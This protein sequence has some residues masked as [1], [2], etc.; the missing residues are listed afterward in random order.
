MPRLDIRRNCDWE[1]VMDSGRAPAK[2]ELSHCLLVASS[3]ALGRNEWR[4]DIRQCHDHLL[5]HDFSSCNNG[6]R[7]RRSGQLTLRAKSRSRPPILA[8]CGSRTEGEEKGDDCC[9]CFY[10]VILCLLC[11]G[12]ST[13]FRPSSVSR[14]NPVRV[15]PLHRDKFATPSRCH[16]GSLQRSDMRIPVR[17]FRPLP[18]LS[19]TV[20]PIVPAVLPFL[21]DS[22]LSLNCVSVQHPW[23]VLSIKPATRSSQGNALGYFNFRVFPLTST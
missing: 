6:Y 19:P 22:T 21:S 11:L 1:R 3:I 7:R 16:C 23:P 5:I 12:L 10:R 18:L 9:C 13:A 2:K 14:T 20:Q 8:M 15:T 17:P 4:W